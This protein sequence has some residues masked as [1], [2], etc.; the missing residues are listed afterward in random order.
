MVTS[1]TAF[2][3]IVALAGASTAISIMGIGRR[4]R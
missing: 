1:K 2:D 3:V 4:T